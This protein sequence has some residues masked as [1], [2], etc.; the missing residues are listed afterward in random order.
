M[1]DEIPPWLESIMQSEETDNAKKPILKKKKKQLSKSSASEKG[2]QFN[3]L[4]LAILGILGLMLCAVLAGLSVTFY[5]NMDKLL[6]STPQ[7]VAVA[8]SPPPSPTKEIQKATPTDS[9][10]PAPTAT[11]MLPQA[12]PT[13]APSP[14]ATYAVDPAF[15]N[16]DKITEITKFVEEWRELS[17]PAEE[18]PI[19]FLTR[20]QLRE[21]WRG[22]AFDV[23]ALEAVQTQQEFYAALGLIEPDV[24]WVEVAFNSGTDI[25][26]GYYTPEE[27]AMYVIAE[28]V[29]MF[30]EEEMTFAHE[31]VHALQDYHFDL[32]TIL[33]ENASGDALLAAR[34]LPEGDARAVESFFTFENITEEQIE[35]NIYRYLF[36]EQRTLEGVSPV[37]G[38]FTFFPYTAGEYFVFYL[39]IEGNF[40]WD[41][42]N[43]AYSHPPVSTEQVMHPEKY[44][45]GEMPTP[46]IVPDLLS[47]LGEGWREIDKDVLGEI[48]F[49]VWLI[50]QVDVETAIDSAAGWNGDT[51]TL[52]VDDAN[53]RVL[54]ESS[55]WETEPDADEVFEAF[56]NYMNLR[57]G[58]INSHQESGT[59]FWEYNEGATLL[60][61]QGRSIL[62]II[63]P[64]RAI[65][66]NVRNQFN[67]F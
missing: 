67:N 48:G 66:D 32:S 1:T 36:Q 28:S 40:T 52:W 17:L 16:K 14:I 21:Q 60:T 64:N 58:Q 49:L 59:Y 38:V 26:M 55:V 18:V 3:P 25:L 45:A 34:S 57:E 23:A 50:D 41:L 61:Q 39:L 35:Y 56:T 4:Q 9:P 46:V 7:P 53:Q 2:D 27:K 11:S 51:Y 8:P 22:E 42:V 65:L 10:T 5:L 62:I 54:A 24:D 63:A 6:G 33:N 13:A 31:Y 30:S 47:A 20:R 29:N 15:I 12:A 43:D 37:L 44:L 19:K